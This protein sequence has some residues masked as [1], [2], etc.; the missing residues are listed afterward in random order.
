MSVS[1]C[2]QGWYKSLCLEGALIHYTLRVPRGTRAFPGGP[3]GE[4]FLEPGRVREWLV[5]KGNGRSHLPNAD[6]SDQFL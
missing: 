4:G 1:L 6:I 2:S 3:G 5:L